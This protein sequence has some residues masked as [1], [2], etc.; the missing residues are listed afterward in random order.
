MKYE[1]CSIDSIGAF[2]DALRSTSAETVV[3]FRGQRR[4]DW[5]LLPNI[6]RPTN[7]RPDGAL[8]QEAAAIK[9]FRQNAGAFLARMPEDM[10]QLIFLMQHHRG[11]TRLLDWSE[12]PLVALYFALEK[13]DDDEKAVVWCLDP[14]GLN[15]HAGH[16]RRNPRDVL[17]F[18][19]DDV[20]DSYLPDRVKP[21]D[22]VL[23]PVAGIG[24][25]N[26]ARMVAQSGTF[27]II[28]ADPQAI[29]DVEGGAHVWRFIIPGENKSSLRDDLRLIGFNEFML[30]PDL[31]R[32]ALYT[33]ELLE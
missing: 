6:A 22:T 9:R 5:K 10:W 7:R 24:P 18:G 27:T 21:G 11:L 26:S 31:E 8:D 29:E 3:W 13:G 16:R 15:E 25:R 4:M 30:F 33:K 17:G 32:V 20:L 23:L 2:V 14:M 12:S 1:D 28:H 19:D